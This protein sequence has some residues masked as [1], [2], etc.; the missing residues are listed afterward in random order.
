MPKRKATAS[1]EQKEQQSNRKKYYNDKRRYE[2]DGCVKGPVFNFEGQPRGKFCATN[3][4]PNI[5]KEKKRM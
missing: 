4:Q 5:V 2:H 1:G 3:K